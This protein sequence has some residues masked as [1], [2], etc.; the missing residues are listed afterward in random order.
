ML[1]RI[2]Y[3][4]IILRTFIKFVF[5]FVFLWNIELLIFMVRIEKINDNGDDDKSYVIII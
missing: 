5:F 1:D 2:I 3:N 4:S